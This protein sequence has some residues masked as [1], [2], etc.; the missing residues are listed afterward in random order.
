MLLGALLCY[1]SVTKTKLDMSQNE[2]L[3]KNLYLNCHLPC[4][5][6]KSLRNI[7]LMYQMLFLRIKIKIFIVDNS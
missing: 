2:L 5:G 4:R 1:P 3:N 6:P 7:K